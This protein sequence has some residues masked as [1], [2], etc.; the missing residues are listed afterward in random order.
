VDNV[1]SGRWPLTCLPGALRAGVVGASLVALAACSAGNDET[2]IIFADVRAAAGGTEP[3]LGFPE[4]VER[5][6]DSPSFLSQTG[7]FADLGSLRVSDGILPYSVQSPLWSDG[8]E[9]LRWLALP[10]GAVIGFSEQAEWAFP[11]GTVFIKHFG[12][13]LDERS[14]EDVRRLETRFLIAARRGDYYGLVYKWDADQLDATLLVDG[15]EEELSIVQRDGSIRPQTYTYPRQSDC[16]TCHSAASGYVM[17]VRTAQLNGP[18]SYGALEP[19]IGRDVADGANQLAT[20]SQL[21]FLDSTVGETPLSDYPRLAGIDEE[22]API[23]QRVRSYWDSN[24]STCHNADSPI[25]S[26]DAR[27]A[28][29]L[30]EQGVLMAEPYTGPREDEVRLIVPGHPERSLIYLRAD[31]SAPRMRM[32]PLFRN[33]IDQDYVALLERWILA[34]PEQ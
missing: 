24:C 14:P 25:P 5:L 21:G 1:C 32:P 13:V 26:W 11:E 2:H 7:G 9:K 29:P 18:H 34:L 10:T 20:L 4:S 8:A 28:T 30:A 27:Y 16:G 17:G 19:N 6:A 23:E 15:D 12:M 33:R 3:F 31:S 22:S